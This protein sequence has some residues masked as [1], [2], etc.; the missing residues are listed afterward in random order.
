MYTIQIWGFLQW[1]YLLFSNL[2]IHAKGS[3]SR[4]LSLKSHF[5]FLHFFARHELEFCL[6]PLG[7][8]VRGDCLPFC[9]S[10]LSLHPST[11]SNRV[12]GEKWTRVDRVGGFPGETGKRQRL[13]FLLPFLVNYIPKPLCEISHLFVKWE[14]NLCSACHWCSAS[15]QPQHLQDAACSCAWA[16]PGLVTSSHQELDWAHA[17][18]Q[19]TSEH[20][21]YLCSP[22]CWW[23]RWKNCMSSGPFSCRSML[24]YSVPRNADLHW[25][26]NC[27]ESQHATGSCES[28]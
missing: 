24:L 19:Q 27:S 3:E 5:R 14:T 1:W 7:M 17:W 20:S 12:I 9:F 16:Y 28:L 4:K 21:C 26:Q 8:V 25:C 18:L 2:S 22:Q 13:G 11:A 23:G 10:S 15:A 6:E